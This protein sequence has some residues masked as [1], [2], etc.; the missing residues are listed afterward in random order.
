M[1]RRVDQKVVTHML[2]MLPPLDLRIHMLIWTSEFVLQ[3]T[4]RLCMFWSD[5]R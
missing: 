3:A 2:I 4:S 5:L 1:R